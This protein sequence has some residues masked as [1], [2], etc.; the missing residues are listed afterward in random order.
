MTVQVVVPL[1]LDRAFTYRVPDALTE[2]AQVG[3]RVVVPFGSRRLS[4]LITARD[5]PAPAG[6]FQIKDVADVLDE[7]P[8][9]NE[10]LLRLTRWIADYY[11]CGHGEVV[12]TALPPGATL[13]DDRKEP[14]TSVKYR[15]HVRFAPAYASVDADEMLEELRGSK[16]KAVVEAMAGLASVGETMPPRSEIM[17]R[18]EAS[19]QTVRSLVAKGMIE[20][21]EKEAE[22]SALDD[23]PEP[24]APRP[25]TRHPAQQN[26]LDKIEQAVQERRFETFL[27]HGVTGSGKTEVY[28]SALKTV[29]AH[30]R[31]GIILVPEIALTPQT[32][33]RFRAHFPGRIAVLH[34]RMSAGERFDAWRRLRSGEYSIAI[35]PRSAIFAPLE[36][37]G[38]IVVDEE[39]EGSYK[40]F[41]PAPRYHARDVAV[42][43]AHM[44]DAVCVLGSAT[45]SLESEM[46]ARWGKYTKLDM[47]DRV[48]VPGH[49]AAPLPPVT[50]VDLTLERKK[51]QLEGVIAAPLRE[52]LRERID[53]GEQAI[54]LQNRRGYAPVIECE[55]CGWS[56]ECPDCAVTLTY[57]KSHRQLRCHYCGRADRLP[58]RCPSCESEALSQ[59]GTGTQRVEEELASFLPDARVV[60]MDRDT[61]AR[62]GA[63]HRL[64]SSFGRGEADILLGTQMVAK[65]L[66]FE[67]VTLVGVINSDTG[68]LL[69]DFR[70]EERTFQLLTQ[71]AGRSG[72][73]ELAGEVILQTR[74]PEHPALQFA[75]T[76]D[77]RSFAEYALDERRALG[78]PP[79]GRLAGVEFRGPKEAKVRTMA[80]K[81]TKGIAPVEGLTVMGPQPALIS[82]IKKS[83]RYHTLL[84]TGRGDINLQHVLRRAQETFGS[85][86]NGYYIA[87]DVDAV[88]LF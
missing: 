17:A 69:P 80:E 29:L 15:K 23:L 53:R 63:H 49:E 30:D 42:M 20:C 73:S 19:A 82:R 67:Q 64:L 55:D 59:L 11:V 38:L 24:D 74:N 61:T 16:Q 13:S 39:H 88:G 45:P 27:L 57:H 40:Q 43:R 28:I 6:D 37:L 86:K 50:V 35:G 41:D 56:P 44:N 68:L 9:L 3:C 8:A 54:L 85:P 76:H 22:R 81:W 51:H 66:D 18:A 71:V 52:A 78:Y 72:R 87:V 33:Q 14:R 83:Y 65:G 70:A 2:K 7:T 32:V 25:I 26:A 46:N 79:F 77:Y 36:D 4:G 62:K 58:Q 48:P 12:K 21:V 5:T 10:E 34:S 75:T 1:P 31:T 60:R 84:K 47:P